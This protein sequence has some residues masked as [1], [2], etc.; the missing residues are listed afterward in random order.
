MQALGISLGDLE[1]GGWRASDV[2]AEV[3]FSATGPTL[4]LALGQLALPEIPLVLHEVALRCPEIELGEVGIRC[5]RGELRL[6]HPL[7]RTED[8][9]V[10]LL[11]DRATGHTSARVTG[12]GLAKGEVSASFGAEGESWRARLDLENLSARDLMP[13]MS[14]QLGDF[15]AQISG[16]V[17]LA[18]QAEGNSAGLR[19]LDWQIRVGDGDLS[20]GAGRWLGED[21]AVEAEGKLARGEDDRWRGPASLAVT[22][23]GLL[24][25]YGFLDAKSPLELRGEVT[26]DPPSGQIELAG[27]NLEHPPLLGLRGRASLASR[28]PHLLHLQLASHATDLQGL[29]RRYFH[30]VLAETP[31][32][33]LEWKGEAAVSLDWRPQGARRVT[34]NLDTVSLE[35]RPGE[36][37]GR[38]RFGL[39]GASGRLVWSA[40]AGGTGETSTLSWTGGHLLGGLSFGS[41]EVHFELH[42]DAIRLTDPLV[43][44]VL[45]GSLLVDRLEIG[46]EQNKSRQLAFDGVLTPVSMERV[47]AALDWPPLSGTLSGVIPGLSLDQGTLEVKGNLLIGLFE[48][49]VLVRNLHLSDLFG[50]LPALTA[51]LQL[52]GLDLE[53]L[54]RT[55]GFGKITGRLEGEVQGLRLEGWHPVAFAAR[56]ATPADDSTPHRISQQAV[57][58]LSALGGGVSGA[59]SR[60]FLGLFQDFNYD[61]LGIGC[62]LQDGVCQ[63]E[64]VTPAEQGYYLVVGRGVPQINVIGFNREV[65]WNE[66]VARLIRAVEA[67]PPVVQ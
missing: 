38:P 21:L 42:G 44:P 11:L 66:L 10:S 1:G 45:D 48:G 53:T 34:A 19:R 26:F 3:A 25:P 37:G 13:L 41:A 14:E 16:Q 59:V 15:R 29:Y 51:N 35:D 57:E 20:A 31:W 40:G 18:L 12:L 28:P 2:R 64:G 47:S 60:G 46:W 9:R 49:D 63:M 7:I 67:G 23:G 22:A 27:L 52:R 61:R 8:A 56:L 55:F 39:R 5:P 6:R 43:L 17:A 36:A 24:S 33:A 54:T 4:D 32:Q 30:P 50:A 65:D 58:N 62:R